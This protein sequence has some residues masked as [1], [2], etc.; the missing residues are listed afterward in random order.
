M[1]QGSSGGFYRGKF[2]GWY[3]YAFFL[4]YIPAVFLGF[5]TPYSQIGFR[6]RP[7]AGTV[8]KGRE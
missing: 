1:A 5:D 2:S 8:T 4:F 6:I 7:L 3:K